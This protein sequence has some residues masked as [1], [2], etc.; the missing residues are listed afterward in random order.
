MVHPEVEEE[1]KTVEHI[2]TLSQQ[3]LESLWERGYGGIDTKAN[4]ASKD[5]RKARARELSSSGA[6]TLGRMFP[7]DDGDVYVGRALVRDEQGQIV[8]ISWAADAATA[9]YQASHSEPQG[10][11]RRRSFQY[12][13]ILTLIDIDEQVFGDED[14]EA[15][16]ADESPS[17]GDLLLAE[18]ERSRSGGMRDIVATIQAEQ[19]RLIR[20]PL[21]GI[22]L[23]QG[24]PGTG[25]T[26]VGLHRAA[27]LLYT[28]R[29][30]L[31]DTGVLV[32]GPNP[33]FMRYVRHVLPVLGERAVTQV[34]ISQLGPRVSTSDTEPE[35]VARLKGDARMEHVLQRA[36]SQRVRP[37]EED[38]RLQQGRLRLPREEAGDIVERIRQSRTPHNVGREQ[39]RDEWIRAALRR[40]GP[41]DRVGASALRNEQ[42]FQAALNRTW[43]QFTAHA[44]LL[45]LFQTREWLRQAAEGLLSEEEQTVLRV[46]REATVNDHVWQPS[47]LPLLDE[48][49]ALLNGSPSNYGHVV[50]DE[51]QEL[52]PMQ[53]RMVARRSRGGSMTL[54]GD[55]AQ[56]TGPCSPNTWSEVIDPL[57]RSAGWQLNTLPHSYRVPR[58]VMA[59]AGRLLPRLGADVAPPEP[60]RDGPAEPAVVDAGERP[61]AQAVQESLPEARDGV[62]AIIAPDELVPTLEADLRAELALAELDATADGSVLLLPATLAKGIE[63]DHV[64]V[65]EPQHIIEQ[66]DA[67]LRLLYVALTRATQTLTVVH[68]EPLPPALQGPDTPQGPA[69]EPTDGSQR[70]QSTAF[71]LQIEDEHADVWRIG[72]ELEGHASAT[73]DVERLTVHATLL[74]SAANGWMTWRDGEIVVAW[75]DRS[76]ELVG[77]CR[78]RG[79]TRHLV[80]PATADALEAWTDLCT[81]LVRQLNAQRERSSGGTF[82][83]VGTLRTG[84]GSL[85]APSSKTRCARETHA[86]QTVESLRGTRPASPYHPRNTQ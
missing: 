75:H 74:T 21:E 20:A 1:R 46:S 7:E 32:V 67:G 71:A 83:R 4:K 53:L 13:D 3:E 10:L 25:K 36:L 11:A 22:Q 59:Y 23:I 12:D 66:R 43:P 65:V 45:Q 56:G 6:L 63:F 42:A 84:V 27:R 48:A 29:D 9:Y 52:S 34:S 58:Q 72:L 86:H 15:A 38:L 40:A 47:D 79:S 73:F 8:Q 24:G 68:R 69:A 81:R 49:E 76:H 61:L 70:N 39:L 54:L 14:A 16:E 35:R 51:V 57:P 44:F 2:R 31:S 85:R 62:T 33:A 82:E 55:I 50:V 26:A 18:L 5:G 64:V 41:R 28:H 37:L 17:M 60:L 30:K 19:D 77:G 80:R 78:L